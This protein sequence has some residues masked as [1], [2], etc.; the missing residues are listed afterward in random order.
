[1]V[2]L[3]PE[4]TVVLGGRIEGLDKAW[5]EGREQRLRELVEKERVERG[6]DG[7]GDED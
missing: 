7:D 4:R 6:G 2:L 1:M 3:E 5:R